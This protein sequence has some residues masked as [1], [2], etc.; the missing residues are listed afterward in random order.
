M[1]KYPAYIS[2]DFNEHDECS[3]F[4]DNHYYIDVDIFEAF[5]KAVDA[6]LETRANSIGDCVKLAMAAKRLLK[7]RTN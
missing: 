3:I 6:I 1:P 4:V 2:K 5:E 7:E